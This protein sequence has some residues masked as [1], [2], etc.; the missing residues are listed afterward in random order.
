M[1]DAK[2]DSTWCARSDS[3]SLMQRGQER[4]QEAG[5]R[6]EGWRDE[7]ECVSDRG[8]ALAAS[9]GDKQAATGM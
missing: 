1:R 3:R 9:A 5:E 7:G 2:I 6:G 8:Q 4:V